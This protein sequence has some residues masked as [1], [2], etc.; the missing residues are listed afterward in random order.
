[1]KEILKNKNMFCYDG[2]RRN[3]YFHCSR[4]NTHFSADE[5]CY[6][7]MDTVGKTGYVST[8]PNCKSLILSSISSPSS[9]QT[10]AVGFRPF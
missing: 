3:K 7:F 2:E 10:P 4:C 9:W 1:M 6:T 5:D 8:C